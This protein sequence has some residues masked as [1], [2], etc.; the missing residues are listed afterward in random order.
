MFNICKKREYFEVFLRN[1]LSIIFY[2]IFTDKIM[3]LSVL[4]EFS[5]SCSL[6]IGQTVR[7]LVERLKRI[8]FPWKLRFFIFEQ[9]SNWSIE[10][11]IW[12]SSK[13]SYFSIRPCSTILSE[14]LRGI[15]NMKKPPSKFYFQRKL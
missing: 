10:T 15:I 2:L 3:R 5:N 6:P 13:M 8:T 9:G 7:D 14:R 4:E 11:A 12:E 1:K